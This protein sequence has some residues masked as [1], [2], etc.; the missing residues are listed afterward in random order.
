[1]K[2]FKNKFIGFK[3]NIEEMNKYIDK[4]PHHVII[5]PAEYKE[6]FGFDWLYE[7]DIVEILDKRIEEKH[8]LIKMVQYV[9]PLCHCEKW[10]FPY[11]IG[12]FTTEW[13]EC[14]GYV[15]NINKHHKFY[16]M[17]DIYMANKTKTL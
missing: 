1:M 4:M 12:H 17:K 16:Y 5:D 7:Q 2:Q 9:C 3:R 14:C 11:P 10:K 8:D 6:R 15:G 13:R